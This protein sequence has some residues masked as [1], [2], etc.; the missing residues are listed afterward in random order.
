MNANMKVAIVGCGA[1]GSVF[2]RGLAKTGIHLR[3]CDHT[4]SRAVTLAK[5]VGGEAFEDVKKGCGSADLILL[6]VKPHDLQSSARA[7]GPLKAQQLVISILTGVSLELLRRTFPKPVLVRLMP[8]LA[9]QQGE[10]ILALAEDKSLKK[11][12]R[13]RLTKLLSSLGHLFWIEESKMDALTALGGSGPAFLIVLLEA[14]I[15]GGVLLGL[16]V[17]LSTR[18]VEQMA[19]GTLAL[20]RA[21]KNHPGALRWQIASPGGTTIH[22]LKA[23]EEGGAR[24]AIL[25]ALDAAAKRAKEIQ[26]GL[27]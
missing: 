27:T 2:A 10:A 19:E 16:D 18:L 26:K 3:L 1:M 23:L 8:N 17:Q 9:I 24:A 25:N 11:K 20:L 12:E 14:F 15:E 5:E 6:A 4:F 7:I 21:H 13:D 22:G